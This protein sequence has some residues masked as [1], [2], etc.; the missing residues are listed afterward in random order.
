MLNARLSSALV[1][2]DFQTALFFVEKKKNLPYLLGLDNY[3]WTNRP[4]KRKK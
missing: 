3:W 2:A 1:L 4:V